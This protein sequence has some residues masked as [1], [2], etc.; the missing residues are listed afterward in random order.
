MFVPRPRILDVPKKVGF[1]K[2]FTVPVSIPTDLQVKKVQGEAHN[3]SLPEARLNNLL[4]VTLVDLGFSTH[5][6]HS[7]ARLVFLDHQLSDDRRSLTFTIPPHPNIYP[8]GPAY[9]FL[10]VDD[11]SSEGREVLVGTGAPPPQTDFV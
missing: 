2:Q 4:P 6:F 1:G 7:S 11:I 3:T 5:A 9:I 8:P 10:T